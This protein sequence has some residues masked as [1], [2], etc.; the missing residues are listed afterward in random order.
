MTA[1]KKRDVNNV[2]AAN[3]VYYAGYWGYGAAQGH[4]GYRVAQSS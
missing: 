4:H 1:N 3:L 2:Y